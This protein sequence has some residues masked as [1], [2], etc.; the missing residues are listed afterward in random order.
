MNA[1]VALVM[2]GAC[3]GMTLAFD[4]NCNAK[5]A[6][7]KDCHKKIKDQHEQDAQTREA[8]ISACYTASS[9]TPPGQGGRTEDP[10]REQCRKDIEVHI[11]ADMEKCVTDKVHGLVIPQDNNAHGV[12]EDHRGMRGGHGD[13]GVEK[14][15]GTNTAGVAAVK[16]CIKAHAG[17]GGQDPKARFDANCKAKKDCDA[18]LGSCKN[19]LE[20]AHKAICDC[21]ESMHGSDARAK[22]EAST[23]S[24][25]GITQGGPHQGGG[26]K[27]TPKP[28]DG[29]GQ[30]DPCAGSYDDWQKARAAHQG[31]PGGR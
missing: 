29:A 30:K 13:K 5:I 25:A 12:K 3:I 9:C 2:L 7:F 18:V 15:C 17:Q 24:C 6:S 14:A 20:E 4:P 21:Q 31:G 11:K 23:P 8:A 1:I 27:G 26:P 22:L 19:D 16:A 28:C 10:K